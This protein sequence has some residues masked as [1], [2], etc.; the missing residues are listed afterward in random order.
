MWTSTAPGNL[1][2]LGGHARGVGEAGVHVLAE[3]LHVD[4]GGQ[5]EIQDL[6]DDVGWLEEEF[7]AGKFRRQRSAQFV[8]VA[9]G[10]AVAFLQ[11]DQ[12]FRVERADDAGIAVGQVDAA[13][14]Q[15]DIVEDRLQFVGRDGLAAGT[16]RPRRRGARFP[17]RA[18]RWRRA[19]AAGSRSRRRWERNP[20][21]A[22]RSGRARRDRRRRRPGQRR[23]GASAAR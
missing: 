21:R 7:D 5:A 18:C 9:A 1:R 19:C 17:R 23:A 6:G 22:R 13:I 14:G 15:A 12:D 8:D 20:A 2:I 4:G 3:E 11:R 16:G 10:R